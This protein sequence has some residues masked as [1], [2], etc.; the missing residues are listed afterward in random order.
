M[1]KLFLRLATK[2]YCYVLAL[3]AIMLLRGL[4]F[5]NKLIW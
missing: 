5:H 2:T 1:V 3:G 4:A